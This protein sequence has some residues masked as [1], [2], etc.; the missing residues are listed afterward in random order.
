MPDF[1]YFRP[2][3]SLRLAGERDYHLLALTQP[4]LIQ[5]R[6]DSK[7]FP[8]PMDGLLLITCV[9]RTSFLAILFGCS[10]LWVMA[11]K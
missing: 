10:G 6:G 7:Q 1:H 5:S 11:F 9:I 3:L 4:G 2:V 8:M